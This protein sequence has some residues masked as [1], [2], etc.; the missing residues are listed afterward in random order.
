MA[1]A[2]GGFDKIAG[3]EGWRPASPQ[4]ARMVYSAGAAK[5]NGTSLAD[6]SRRKSRRCSSLVHTF[7]TLTCPLP[8]SRSSLRHPSYNPQAGLGYN[9]LNTQSGWQ[10]LL[11]GYNHKLPLLLQEVLDRLAAF[12][13]CISSL[14]YPPHTVTCPIISLGSVW[15]RVWLAKVACR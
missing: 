11:S 9:L 12:K 5:G 10:L 1:R 6:I 7:L 14:A 13:V 15:P 4:P 8:F 2:A 3:R